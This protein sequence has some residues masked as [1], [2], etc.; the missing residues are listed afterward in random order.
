M[1][2]DG[3]SATA[4]VAAAAAM[5]ASLWLPLADSLSL[6]APSHCPLTQSSQKK[7]HQHGRAKREGVCGKRLR[8]LRCVCAAAAASAVAAAAATSVG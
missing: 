2:L 5:V 4:T 3:V 7:K 8:V 6:S 1:R